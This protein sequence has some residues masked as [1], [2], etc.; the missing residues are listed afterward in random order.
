MA[1]PFHEGSAQVE[2][3][4]TGSEEGRRS[5]W[6]PGEEGRSHLNVAPCGGIQSIPQLSNRGTTKTGAVYPRQ[7]P[8]GPDV[9]A[10]PSPGRGI[11]GSSRGGITAQQG[12]GRDRD[13]CTRAHTPPEPRVS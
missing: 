7:Q 12:G 9:P 8:V 6:L 1:T 5:S 10:T 11:S 3:G 4:E 13:T 2:R